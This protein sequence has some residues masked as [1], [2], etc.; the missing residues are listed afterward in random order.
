MNTYQV[1]LFCLKK[2]NALSVVKIII[3]FQKTPA[4]TFSVKQKHIQSDLFNKTPLS[5]QNWNLGSTLL[6]NKLQKMQKKNLP[7]PPFLLGI[8]IQIYLYKSLINNL[9]I[10]WLGKHCGFFMMDYFWANVNL[11]L[12]PGTVHYN[13]LLF[14]F[15]FIKYIYKKKWKS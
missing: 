9:D 3:S 6:N 1:I 7:H 2:V 14:C 8:Y 12:T 5:P 15:V 4:L 10:A 13:I 11:T